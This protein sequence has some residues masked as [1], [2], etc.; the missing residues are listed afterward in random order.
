MFQRAIFFFVV[1]DGH[2]LSG[3]G[4]C[5]VRE[6]KTE[7]ETEIKKKRDTPWDSQ[8]P[9]RRHNSAAAWMSFASKSA[10]TSWCSSQADTAE[11]LNWWLLFMDFMSNSFL[12]FT[13]SLSLLFHLFSCFVSNK[14]LFIA[15]G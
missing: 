6:T 11:C 4:P 7:T 14:S 2:T 5:R 10:T 8:E 3:E 15:L 12:T 13:R 1:A 9:L